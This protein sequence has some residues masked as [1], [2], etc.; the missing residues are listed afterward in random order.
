MPI[1]L[2]AAL[3]AV[4]C[5]APILTA[6]GMLGGGAVPTGTGWLEPLGFVLVGGGVAGLKRSRGHSAFGTRTD[7][8]TGARAIAT[9]ATARHAR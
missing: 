9:V 5:S 8:V 4:C 3:C 2:G 6:A 1:G 7:A